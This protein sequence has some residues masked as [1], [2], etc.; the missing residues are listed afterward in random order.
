[1]DVDFCTI[2]VFAADGRRKSAGQQKERLKILSRC[3][4][5]RSRDE[6]CRTAAISSSKTGRTD[7]YQTSKVDARPKDRHKRREKKKNATTKKSY[8]F[9]SNL[10]V[11]LNVRSCGAERFVSVVFARFSRGSDLASLAIGVFSS[12]SQL[13]FSLRNFTSSTKRKEVRENKTTK[14]KRSLYLNKYPRTIRFL[15]FARP[16]TC[17]RCAARS[18]WTSSRRSSSSSSSSSSCSSSSSSSRVHSASSLK[19]NELER[20]D[21]KKKEKNLNLGF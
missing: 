9:D 10:L 16:D 12:S 3:S 21:H 18:H 4:I 19:Y 8:Q 11:R 17:C 15:S 1:M 14:T 2:P 6:T 20:E 5:A 7:M 13:A